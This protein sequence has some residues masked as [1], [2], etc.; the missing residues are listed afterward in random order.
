MKPMSPTRIRIYHWIHQ[1]VKTVFLCSEMERDG[2]CYRA[3]TGVQFH[4]NF[5]SHAF[6]IQSRGV[7]GAANPHALWVQQQIGG[8]EVHQ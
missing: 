5:G 2:L 1:P 3:G 4:D 6:R 7:F 8:F